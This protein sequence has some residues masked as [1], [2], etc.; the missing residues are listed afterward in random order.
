MQ[1]VCKNILETV[2]KTPLVKLNSEKWGIACSILAKLEFFNPTGSVKDRIALSMIQAAERDG[3][4]RPGDGGLIVEPT[5]GNTGAGI[6]MVAASK[7]YAVL[8]VVQDKVSREKQA[9]LNAFGAEVVVVPA[10]I[11]R[12]E[13]GGL[14][15]EAQRIAKERGG[16]MLDQYYNPANRMAHYSTTGPEL[17]AQ[18]G[19]QIDALVVCM[20]TCGTISGTGGFLKERI[21]RVK[22]IGVEPEG[23]IFR[24]GEFKSYLVEAIGSDFIPGNLDSSVVDEIV[25]VGDA[26]AFKTARLLAKREGIFAGGSSGAA[27]FGALQAAKKYGEGSVI[28]TIFPDSGFRYLSKFYD[29]EWLAKNGLEKSENKAGCLLNLVS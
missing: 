11:P 2:G 6:A 18:S 9:L 3:L 4:L 25:G 15:Y 10:K 22:V 21:P 24:G 27:L 16:V 14:Y 19:G 20:G 28:A 17:F 26:D 12:R 13:P 8:F 1:T 5:S 23:S 7:G 29:D